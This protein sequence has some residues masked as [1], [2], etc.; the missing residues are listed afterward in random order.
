MDDPGFICPS[1]VADCA[2]YSQMLWQS[3]YYLQ[4]YE[5]GKLTYDQIPDTLKWVAP[6]PAPPGMGF[7]SVVIPEDERMNL[8]LPDPTL[9]IPLEVIYGISD[10]NAT[11]GASRYGFDWDHGGSANGPMLTVYGQVNAMDLWLSG[12]GWNETLVSVGC[13]G[14]TPPTT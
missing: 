9:Q 7:C 8:E 13:P 14:P 11:Y 1:D 4:Q 6:P 12:V 3:G 10:P 5:D 2:G